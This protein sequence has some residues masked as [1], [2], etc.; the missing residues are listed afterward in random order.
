MYIGEYVEKAM[1][2]SSQRGCIQQVLV[3]LYFFMGG[4]FWLFIVELFYLSFI[5]CM[6]ALLLTPLAGLHFCVGLDF[7][8]PLL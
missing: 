5:I 4:M 2:F 7:V 6:L 3:F 1:Q 8:T